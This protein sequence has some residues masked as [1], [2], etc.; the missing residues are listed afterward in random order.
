MAAV[1]DLA[2]LISEYEGD[3]CFLND[4]IEACDFVSNHIKDEDKQHFV[5]LV[6]SKLKGRA[7]TCISSRN[8]TDWETMKNLLIGHFGDCRDTASLLRD[9]SSM[10]QNSSEA[11]RAFFDR[12]SNMNTKVRS[13][14]NLD[15]NTDAAGKIVLNQAYEQHAL[16]TL[17]AGLR[18]PLGQVVRS[19]KPNSLSEAAQL[20]I[21]EE[22]IVY[23]QSGNETITKSNASPTF[24]NYCKKTGH[25]ISVCRKR[26]YV[27]TNQSKS[28]PNHATTQRINPFNTRINSLNET[29]EQSADQTPPLN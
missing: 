2:Y 10:W 24:C 26:A 16:R 21:E 28:A 9:L 29:E 11:G 22:R 6:K 25:E 18:S 14:V 20:I 3:Q 17:L 23:A 13:S 27:N 1:R 4:F 19:Q 12:I 8:V 15:T 5:L 7:K